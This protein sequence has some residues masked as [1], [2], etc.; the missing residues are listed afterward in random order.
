MPAFHFSNVHTV[1]GERLRLT[2]AATGKT[3][4]EVAAEAGI[5]ARTLSRIEAGKV[6]FRILTLAKI[7]LVYKIPPEE[8]LAGIIPTAQKKIPE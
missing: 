1:I 4:K 5:T 8:L 2:R 3:I 6:E 7:S